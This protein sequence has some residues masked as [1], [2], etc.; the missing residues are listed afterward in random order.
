M[1]VLKHPFALFLAISLCL[2]SCSKTDDDSLPEEE[3]ME[4]SEPPVENQQ[5][6]AKI[7]GE[8]FTPPNDFVTATVA[9]ESEFYAIGIAAAGPT[10]STTAK[11]I[12]LAMTGF[13]FDTLE[14]GMTW[15]LPTTESPLD[16]ATAAF[17]QGNLETDEI[18]EIFVRLTNIDRVQRTISG[19]FEFVAL[20]E[21]TNRIYTV[22]DGL[23]RNVVYDLN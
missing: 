12:V 19:E 9:T 16:G 17:G 22:T 8:T 5:F 21:E 10:S 2:I 7:N 4:M 3:M 20:D 14:A 13:N 11:G 18:Q 1:N 23:F 6:S 15:S